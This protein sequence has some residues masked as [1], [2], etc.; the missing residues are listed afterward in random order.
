MEGS[1]SPN[2]QGD[3]QFLLSPA[4]IAGSIVAIVSAFFAI[5]RF[6]HWWRPIRVTPAVAFPTNERGQ[7][8]ATVTNISNEELVVVECVARNIR[9]V[10]LREALQAFYA[11]RWTY[12]DLRRTYGILWRTGFC[13]ALMAPDPIRFKPM[14]RRELTH[15]LSKTSPLSIFLAPEFQI[16]VHLSNERIFRSQW[17]QVPKHW[18]FRG[19]AQ[20]KRN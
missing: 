5:R 8:L 18:R 3:W 11:S 4:V 12:S 19:G 17:M 9:R 1:A 7:I 16:E 15:T 14:E 20:A 6:Y 2:P 13:F 10:T